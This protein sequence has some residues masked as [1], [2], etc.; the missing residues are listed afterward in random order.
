MDEFARG[1]VAD[2]MTYR[3]LCVGPH[4]SLAEAYALLEHARVDCLPVAEDGMLVGV[5]STLD[6]L[7]AFAG[8]AS[9]VAGTYVETMGAP[10]VSVMTEAPVTIRPDVPLA[11]ALQLL[12]ATRYRVLPV[13]IG[14]LLIGMLSRGDVLR[15]LGRADAGRTEVV[16][17]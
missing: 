4:T 7:R 2:A 1:R 5:V 13:T 17:V 8:G 6:V 9:P 10:V 16:V 15:A 11:R 14:A 12:V 3:P